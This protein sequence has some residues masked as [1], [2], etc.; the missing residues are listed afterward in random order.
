MSE[1][2]KKRRWRRWLAGAVV[3]Y[4]GLWAATAAWAPAALQRWED[5]RHFDH[6]TQMGMDP[7]EGGRELRS[8]SVPAPL[9]VGATWRFASRGPDG[10]VG[11]SSEGEVGAVWAF[12]WLGVYRDRMHWVACG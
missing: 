3:A 12:G 5:R 8:F 7:A 2:P 4:A 1:A 10:R 6:Y 11:S 9:V